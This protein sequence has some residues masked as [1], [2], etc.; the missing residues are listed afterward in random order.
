MKGLVTTNTPHINTIGIAK[1]K[2]QC[3]TFELFKFPAMFSH[4]FRILILKN[5]GFYVRAIKMIKIVKN[6]IQ[7]WI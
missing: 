4:K 5:W 7:S 6:Y 3:T 1:W 2:A